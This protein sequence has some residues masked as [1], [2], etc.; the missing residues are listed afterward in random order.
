MT[1]NEREIAFTRLGA[2]SWQCGS[3]MS[4]AAHLSDAAVQHFHSQ[5]DSGNYEAILQE[6]DSA[7][8]NSDSHDELLRF[9]A[10][11]HSKLGASRST[12]RTN[13][14]VNASTRGTFI[15]TTYQSVF[16]PGNAVETFTWTKATGSLKLV[17]Y[18][19]E[20]RRS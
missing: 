2:F 1:V 19:I 4:A 3:G 8:Q 15:K 11:V 14:F 6:S 17:G 5:L 7:F 20:S 18:D 12:R 16:E 10:A 9:M 13:I